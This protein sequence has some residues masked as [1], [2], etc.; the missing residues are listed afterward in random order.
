MRL[1]LQS[2][3]I[4]AAVAILAQAQNTQAVDPNRTVGPQKDGSI[5]ASDNQTLTPA[6]KIVDLGRP[7]APSPSH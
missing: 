4:A 5:V 6:G 2:I 1:P 3:L 7:S